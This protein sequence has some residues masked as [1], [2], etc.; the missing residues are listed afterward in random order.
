MKTVILRAPLL[1]NAGYGVH[2]R[3]IARWLFRE[4]AEKHNLDITTEPLRWGNTHWIN[5][6]E[7]EDGLIGQIVQAAS[8]VKK[9]YDV[10]IQLQLPN[11]W[12]PFLGNFNVGVTAGVETDRCN[13]EWIKNVNRMDL[14]VVPSEFTRQCFLNTGEVKT[15]IVVIPEAFPDQLLDEAPVLPLELP[16]KFNF[17]VFGQFT[18]NNVDNDRKNLGY[19]IKWI[20][21]QFAGNPEVGIVFKT[22]FGANT[23]L[24]RTIVTNICNKMLSEIRANNEGPLVHLLHGDMTVPE[25]K[26]LYTHPQVKALVT[27]THGEGFGLPILEA[28]ACDLPVIATNWSAHTE[29]LSLGKFLSVDYN[30]ETIHPSRVDGQIFMKDAKWA[31][32]TEASS[33]RRLQKFF[34]ST[35]MPKSWAKDLG[36]RIRERYCFSEIAKN[37]DAILGEVLGS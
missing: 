2:A 31:C 15:K 5:D 7:A 26:G 13:P 19:T 23:K 8:N 37:Y 30:M 3:Q 1:C 28:A 32:P 25:L 35:S 34:E 18:G 33:K 17:L 9:F 10:S 20:A 12:N 29:F 27:L 6:V 36:K 4:A 24:D 14:V 16:S 21:E 11:E 22:N